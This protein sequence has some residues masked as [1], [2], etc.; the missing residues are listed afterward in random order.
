M[1]RIGPYRY[2]DITLEEARLIL[3]V[4]L[5][6]Q[7]A[8][9]D[10]PYLAKR[11]GHVNEKSGA[12]KRKLQSLRRWGL[13][14]RK[15]KITPLGLRLASAKTNEEWSKVAVDA[16]NN[17]LLFSQLITML[18]DEGALSSSIFKKHLAILTRAKTEEIEKKWKHIWRVFLSTLESMEYSPKKSE[19][20][21]SR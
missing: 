13:I 18:N 21:N 12:F 2:P 14:N 16:F 20:S 7:G 1:G 4:N 17:V 19:A 9:L 8:S 6:Y 5:T 10:P 11:L 3:L 15:N